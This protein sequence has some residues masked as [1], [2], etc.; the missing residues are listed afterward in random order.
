MV[1]L[2]LILQKGYFCI[3]VWKSEV[4]GNL[5][6]KLHEGWQY[7]HFPG[8]TG[9]EAAQ[10]WCDS[11]MVWTRLGFVKLMEILPGE[12]CMLEALIV[13]ALKTQLHRALCIVPYDG[14]FLLA[15]GRAPGAYVSAE[16]SLNECASAEHVQLVSFLGE[17]CQKLLSSCSCSLHVG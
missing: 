9:L 5:A 11:L 4:W 3:T 17:I 7:L 15:A 8:G 6:F 16:G 1:L 2:I 14:W 10:S 12:L 13:E